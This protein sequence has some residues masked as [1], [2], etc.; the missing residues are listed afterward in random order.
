M[1]WQKV[2]VVER[3]IGGDRPNGWMLLANDMEMMV[4][5]GGKERTEAEFRELFVHA[6]LRVRRVIGSVSATDHA[7]MEGELQ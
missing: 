3:L 5:A 6:G 7:I 2:L 4:T 1:R